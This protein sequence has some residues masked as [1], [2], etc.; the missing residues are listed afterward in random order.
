MPVRQ[1]NEGKRGAQRVAYERGPAHLA[2][3]AEEKRHVEEQ[4]GGQCAGDEHAREQRVRGGEVPEA[5]KRVP[6]C[7]RAAAAEGCEVR[8]MVVRSL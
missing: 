1:S 7:R 5:V 2:A 3:P 6:P 4:A 8:L